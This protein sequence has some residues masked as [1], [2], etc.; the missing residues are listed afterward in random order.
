MKKLL[1]ISLIVITL[2]AL[3]A[4][5]I[6]GD[7]VAQAN[8]STTDVTS[9][10][11]NAKNGNPGVLPPNSKPHGKSYGEW[12]AQWWI[13]ATQQ[14]LAT[15]QVL[16][17]TGE[18]CQLGQSG[19]VWFLAGNFGGTTVR[20]CAIPAGKT[21]FFPMANGLSFAPEFGNTEEEIR[22]D[23]ANDLAGIDV[24]SLR[25]IVDGVELQ[26]LN[27]Y[28]AASPA[29]VLPVP[30][31]GLLTDLGL[32][33]GDRAP[34]VSDGWWIMHTPL[35]KGKHTI[36]IIAAGADGFDLNVTYNLTVGP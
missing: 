21:L 27:S 24:S 4:P 7:Q 16:D 5:G 12:G 3:I 11:I 10:T 13:W 25:V 22:A 31:G 19:S 20:D 9:W 18:F 15:N 8:S 6:T 17:E 34:A 2:L 14:P 29:F 30:V 35:P 33:P 26:D 23:V 1:L 36:Q 32:D 28:R